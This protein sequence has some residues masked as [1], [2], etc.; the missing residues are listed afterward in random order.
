MGK[1]KS[2]SIFAGKTVSL[3]KAKYPAIEEYI[4]IMSFCYAAMVR[5]RV[6]VIK[7]CRLCKGS[8]LMLCS[9]NVR[10]DDNFS[11]FV[12]LHLLLLAIRANL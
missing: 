4:E 10:H 8:P 7:Q 12:D 6:L 9:R 5:V 3:G 2:E 11:L 1:T